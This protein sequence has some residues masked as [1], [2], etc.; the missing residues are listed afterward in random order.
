MNEIIKKDILAILKELIEILK[1]KEAKD[2][3][4]IKEISNHTMHNA[5]IFQ[6]EDSISVAIFIYALSKIIERKQ[7]ELN[8]SAI[9]EIL[10][11]AVDYAQDDNTDKYREKIQKL[12][13]FVA[14]VDTKL[15]LYIEE[16]L[17]QAQ[18]KKGSKLYEHGISLAR[19]AEMLNISQWELM[20]YIGKTTAAE[21]RTE[22]VNVKSR[23]E[24]ARGLFR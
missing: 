1:V 13:K 23:L 14:T 22:T 21:I 3:M 5:S 20:S 4:E 11:D 7:G 12:F 15:E 24:L 19:S 6:D 10:E 8:Y 18:I 9:L 17:K 2:V 16:V